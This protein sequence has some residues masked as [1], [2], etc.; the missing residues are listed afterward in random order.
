[1]FGGFSCSGLKS[2]H[3][4]L[5]N[6]PQSAPVGGRLGACVGIASKNQRRV[7]SERTFSGD[8]VGEG[9]AAGREG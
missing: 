9:R 2:E 3:A 8:T 4:G 1:M 5:W 6:K 7:E